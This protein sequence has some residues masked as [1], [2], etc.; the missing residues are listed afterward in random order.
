MDIKN[1]DAVRQ[2]AQKCRRWNAAVH[3]DAC[4]QLRLAL[5]EG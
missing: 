4:N 1:G 2:L 5:D 3:D